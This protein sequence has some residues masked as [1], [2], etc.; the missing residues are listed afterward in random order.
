VVVEFDE[1]RLT[2]AQVVAAVKKAGYTAEA[3]E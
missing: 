2:E 1:T 3:M